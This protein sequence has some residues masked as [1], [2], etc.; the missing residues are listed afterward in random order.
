VPPTLNRVFGVAAVALLAWACA[1]PNRDPQ[2]TA[3]AQAALTQHPPLSASRQLRRI[4]L[5][6][7]GKEPTLAD[8]Q[9]IAAA[10]DATAKTAILTKA[11]DDG[12]AS[13][14]F[15]DEM[16]AF[17]H[18]WL[19]TSEYTFGTVYPLRWSGSQSIV[20]ERCPAATTHAGA[21]YVYDTYRTTDLCTSTTVRTDSIEPWWAPGTTITT[22]GNVG[23]GNRSFN[24]TDCG[25]ADSQRMGVSTFLEG[26]I[27]GCSCGPN[28]VYCLPKTFTPYGGNPMDDDL[29]SLDPKRARRAMWD[30]PAR[31]F[32]LIATKDRPFTDLILGDSTVVTPSLRHVYNRAARMAGPNDALDDNPWWKTH[33]NPEE[34]RE[35]KI[36]EINPLL[37]ANRAY[38]YDPRTQTG[39]AIGIPS[40]GVLT[41]L[42]SLGAFP[43]E[44]VRA[45]RWL[46]ILTCNQFNAPDPAQ[47]FNVY[48]ND[49]ATQ[50]SCQH[51]HGA[52][53]I[54]A[55]AIHFK[56]VAIRD[57][58]DIVFGGVGAW[59]W[60]KLSTNGSEQRDPEPKERWNTAFIPGTRLTPI[61]AA[62]LTAHPEARM[63]DFLPPGESLFGIPSDGTIGPLGFAKMLVASGLYDRC[64]ARK[65]YG[66]VFGR[67]LDAA[68]EG[69][70]IDALTKQW[71]DGGRQVRP[72]I[73]K[74]LATDEFG[75]GH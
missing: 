74:L 15:Y 7:R 13:T 37:I 70:Y 4:T 33:G 59:T 34:W 12:L 66:K 40:A 51:C 30:E 18:D 10:P 58:G 73:R 6:L 43:R 14:D 5:A 50:G 35:A 49:P 39:Q 60:A 26:G 67:E 42:G 52:G 25:V 11:I 31:L 75:R 71:I 32:A 38:T 22:L 44:R 41:M 56:R 54:D 53:G 64:A 57:S 16:L 55:T 17:G 28:L 24:G 63:I 20:L 27:D 9:A 69:P 48:K 2:K 19:R 21:W 23:A 46:E 47:V 1:S 29:T 68:Q 3:S 62:E 45:A 36:A 65:I 72:F 61:T 8:Y